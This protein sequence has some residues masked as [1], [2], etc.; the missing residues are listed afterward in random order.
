MA[1]VV[2]HFSQGDVEIGDIALEG[3]IPAHAD[4]EPRKTSED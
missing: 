3:Q 4:V 1:G 2:F